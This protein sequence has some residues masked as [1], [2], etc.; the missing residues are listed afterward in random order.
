MNCQCCNNPMRGHTRSSI[1]CWNCYV[2]VKQEKA[3]ACP[4]CGGARYKTYGRCWNCHVK[5]NESKKCRDCSDRNRH[6]G[7]PR[8]KPCRNIYIKTHKRYMQNCKLRGRYGVSI[9]D[10]DMMLV[11][12]DYKCAACQ[13]PLG[14][15]IDTH[16]DHDHVTGTIRGILCRGC[17]MALGCVK[18]S[19]ARLQNLIEYLKSYESSETTRLAPPKAGDDIVRPLWRHRECGRNGRITSDAML[20]M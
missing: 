13:T 8:C 11:Q 1:L 19:Q 4:D 17:N 3:I 15:T 12:Q 14:E 18:D 7:Q 5:Y 10:T 20:W 2:T 9:K 6:G 16:L